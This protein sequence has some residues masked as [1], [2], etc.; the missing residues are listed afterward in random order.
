[1]FF[2]VCRLL[3]GFLRKKSVTTWGDDKMF[4]FKFDWNDDLSLHIKD[5]DEQHKEL[6]RIG[7][8][9]EQLIMIRCIGVKTE[10]LLKI[11]GDLRDYT[12]YH[13]Y[14]EERLM[15]LANYSKLD[16]HTKEHAVFRNEVLNIDMPQLSKNPCK[17][18]K[19]I[20][21]MIQ[22]HVFVHM[23]EKDKVMA[24]E[25]RKKLQ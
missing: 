19:K 3:I 2:K 20:K 17:E 5:V 4:D 12:A 16:E 11:V 10:Q 24:E 21:N 15:K 22:D 6:F 9:I 18:L 13:F 1:M 7:R 25:I 8:D 23:M 14:E